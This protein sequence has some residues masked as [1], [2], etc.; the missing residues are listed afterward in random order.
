MPT[1]ESEAL[2]PIDPSISNPDD[3]EIYTLSDARVVYARSGNGGKKG[4]E[5]SLLAAY[6]DCPLRVEGRLERVERHQGKLLLKKP[7]RPLDITIENV[8]RY[9]Y[10]QTEDGEIMIWALGESG[11]FEIRPA[12][13]YREIY[14]DMVQA[15]EIL[16]FITDIYSEPR[17]RGGG[18]SAGLIFQEYAEDERFACSDSTE[19]AAIF[20]KHRSFLLMCLLS[21][22]Q[23]VGWS[24]T[25]IYQHYKRHY[26]KEF[27]TAKA[28]VEGKNSV[29]GTTSAK[30]E[31][32]QSTAKGGRGTRKPVE[33]S[34]DAP[35]KD[36]NWWE[37]AAIFEFMQKAV[38]Q[39]AMQVGHVTISKVAQLMVKRYQIDEVRTSTDV[40]LVHAENL[41]YMMDHPRRKN[42]QYFANEPIYQ[43]LKR[44][45][46]LSAADIR[47]AQA[48]E[49]HP[50]KDH[51]T[52]KAE[53]SDTESSSSSAATPRRGPRA[54]KK[55]QLSVLRPRSSK[56]S[57]KGKG[58]KRG[59][60]KTPIEEVSSEEGTGDASSKEEEE[61][62]DVESETPIDTPTQALSPKKRKH[63]LDLLEPTNPRKRTAS[64]SI[65]PES[66]PPTS[67]D[68]DEPAPTEPLPLRWRPT[69]TSNG[70]PPKS[71]SLALLPPVISTPL[72][73]FSANGPGDSWICTFDGCS[74]KVYGASTDVGRSLIKEHTEDHSKGR[75]REIGLLLREEEKLRLPV[76]HLIKRIRQMAERQDPLFPGMNGAGPA[77]RPQPIE[78]PV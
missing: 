32:S 60:G 15:V 36:D 59:K 51:A 53:A 45:H 19:A 69:Q 8:T 38:N 44:G 72:P 48:I 25:P 28:R 43:E 68:E 7:F 47:R 62:E 6:A 54:S 42:I 77:M 40:I 55:G 30:R 21:R 34:G 5:A 78:R 50:R 11:W 37:A 64:Q 35:R 26:S 33:K 41:S 16:Y 49:L 67:S 39:R 46:N 22:A 27:D 17:K 65:E 74:H 70:V 14:G 10:G 58:I 2:K 23:G 63:A 57:G 4:A 9:S 29:P 71:S 73:T 52:L 56:Y 24:N 66:P 13:N 31:L 20:D 12:R 76:S 75:V 3:Y 61:D 18:P 1:P